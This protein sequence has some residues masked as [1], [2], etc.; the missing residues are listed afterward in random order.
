MP[1]GCSGWVHNRYCPGGIGIGIG[2]CI[3]TRHGDADADSDAY[4][5]EDNGRVSGEE[6]WDRFVKIK[7]SG[8][9]SGDSILKDEDSFR[10]DGGGGVHLPLYG[11]RACLSSSYQE[12]V[13][14]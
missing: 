9:E 8:G 10:G 6:E 12:S 1:G 4:T 5:A 3:C 13:S 7:M 11:Y 14:S 2:M